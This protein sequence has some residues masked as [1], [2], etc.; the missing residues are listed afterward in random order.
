MRAV[1]EA[2]QA[3]RGVSKVT[4]TTVVAEEIW[5]AASAQSNDCLHDDRA[6]ENDN[7]DFFMVSCPS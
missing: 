1:I 5:S 2:L 4:A 3:M 7:A 6:I